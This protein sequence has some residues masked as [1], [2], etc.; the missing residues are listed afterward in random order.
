LEALV[1]R[2][3]AQRRLQL[4][5]AEHLQVCIQMRALGCATCFHRVE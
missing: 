5:E 3:N 2:I 4:I 1:E